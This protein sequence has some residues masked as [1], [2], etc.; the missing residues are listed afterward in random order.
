MNSST[1]AFLFS[2]TELLVNPEKSA[3]FLRGLASY[4]GS[5]T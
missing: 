1:E 4:H 2:G 5:R 3:G